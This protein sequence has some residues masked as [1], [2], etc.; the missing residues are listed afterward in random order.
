MATENGLVGVDDGHGDSGRIVVCNRAASVM[1][2]STHDNGRHMGCD[3][4]FMSNF[5][6][7]FTE[8]GKRKEGH[9]VVHACN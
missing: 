2:R 3:C 1:K 6:G 8:I 9:V 5:C 4:S 7:S